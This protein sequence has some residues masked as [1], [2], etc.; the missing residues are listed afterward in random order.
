VSLFL[1]SAALDALPAFLAEVAAGPR[2]VFV[3]TGSERSAG[4]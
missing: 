2:T 1:A 4:P 3:P